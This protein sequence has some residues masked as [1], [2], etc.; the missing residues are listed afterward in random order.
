M[1]NG[2]VSTIDDRGQVGPFKQIGC[3]IKLSE[4]PSRIKGSAPAFG[5]HTESILK[6]LGYSQEEIKRFYESKIAE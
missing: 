5:Q 3:P 1:K 6:E 2:L 4:T